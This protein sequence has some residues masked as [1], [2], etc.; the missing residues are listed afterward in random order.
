MTINRFKAVD[1]LLQM[2]LLIIQQPGSLGLNLLPEIL[3][4]SLNY[5]YPLLK[6]RENSNDYGDVELSL[7]S[8]FD[9]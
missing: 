4:Y 3:N 2:L 9:G 7:Y 1:K 6:E 5:V 8:L